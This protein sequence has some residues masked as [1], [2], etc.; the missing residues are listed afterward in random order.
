MPNGPTAPI[1][2]GVSGLNLPTLTSAT[3]YGSARAWAHDTPCFSFAIRCDRAV[4]AAWGRALSPRALEMPALRRRAI[5]IGCAGDPYDDD[6]LPGV[7]VDLRAYRRLLLS[8]EGGAWDDSEIVMLNNPKWGR[9]AVDLLGGEAYDYTLVSFAGHGGFDPYRNVTQVLFADGQAVDL[10]MLRTGS[11][12]ELIITDSCRTLPEGLPERRIKVGAHFG[13]EPNGRRRMSCR[14]AY[15]AAILRAETG[16]S[17]MLA[18]SVGE[19][20]DETADGGGEFTQSLV[21]ACEAW[22]GRADPNRP[23]AQILDVLEGFRR[24][25]E[26]LVMNRVRQ[27]PVLRGRRQRHFPLAVR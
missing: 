3:S 20:A 10:G 22:A 21:G 14:M 26:I 17:F 2:R 4:L 13:Y 27:T 1:D 7:R 9:A 12:R 11:A 16:T 25:R 19:G 8:D 15:D 24:A 5:L 18:C 23:A 6:H